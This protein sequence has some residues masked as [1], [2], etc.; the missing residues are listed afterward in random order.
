M[1]INDVVI[2]I[3][4]IFLIVGAVDF[5]LGKKWGIGVQFEEGI[6]AMGALAL[7]MA[8]IIVIAPLL[9]EFLTPIIVPIYRLFGAD[10]S[11]FA[12]T[13]L[14][15][16]MGGFFLAESMAENPEL[17]RFSGAILGALM[18]P[19]IVFTIPVSL[20]IIEKKD[21]EFLA[22]G[23]LCGLMA[24]P[25]G[26]F[27]GG[28]MQ[29]IDAIV[30]LQ[31]LVPIIIIA[32]LVG[33]G[34]WKVPKKMISGFKFFG[35]FVVLISIIGLVL[36]AVEILTGLTIIRNTGSIIE[37]FEIVGSI[38]ITLSGAYGLVY[39]INKLFKNTLEKIGN[40]LGMNNVA[41]AGL[42]ATLANNIAMFQTLKNMD[43]RGKIINIAF[44][45]CASFTFGDH[46]GFTAGVAQDLIVPMIVSKLSGGIIGI[47]IALFV[48][49]KQFPNVK[50]E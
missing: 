29:G 9:A 3:I 40:S 47:L 41:A 44:A 8:G 13:I 45:V 35:Q 34:L 6:L 36:G 49:N 11:M 17:G 19:T 38:A 25:F 33:L 14:A 43:S 7:S 10:P 22:T 12:G 32:I 21:Q 23:V 27:I 26:G 48:V 20:G 24:I 4:T 18:G 2:W 50:G 28:I 16:D 37:A 39:A 31:N 46:L 1:G 15:N 30:V 42:I 5:C